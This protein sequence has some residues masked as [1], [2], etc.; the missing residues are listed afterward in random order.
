MHEY[1][2]P[3]RDLRLLDPLLPTPYPTSLFVRSK[4]IVI[5]FESLRL[6]VCKDHVRS[7]LLTSRFQG[8]IRSTPLSAALHK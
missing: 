4:A 7:S 1:G 3:F 8:F 5:N 2:V 6:V